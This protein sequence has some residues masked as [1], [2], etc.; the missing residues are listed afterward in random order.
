MG[1][2]RREERCKDLTVQ[3][4]N[5]YQVME[6][7]GSGR[8]EERFGSYLSRRLLEERTVVLNRALTTAVAGEVAEQLTVL[9]AESSAPVRMLMTHVPG[10][11]LEAG[12]STYD[13]LR[14]MTAPVKILGSGRIAGAGLLAFVG[15]PSE[16]R[17]A[18]PHARFRLE[19]PQDTLDPG[20]D[21]EQEA[22]AA[23]ERRTRLVTILAEATNQSEDR[24][25]VDLSHRRAFDAEEALAYGFV[26]RVVQSRREVG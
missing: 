1:N 20:M 19:V 14:S 6:L 23:A 15:A 10:G 7:F 22:K 24:I 5:L 11:D 18:L 3:F 8:S 2:G 26:R 16:R 4:L 9:D 12:F 17:F 21:P 25:G 13:L